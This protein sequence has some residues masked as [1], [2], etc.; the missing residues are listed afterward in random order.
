MPQWIRRAL[1]LF[2]AVAMDLTLGEPPAWAHPVVW[3]GRVIAILERFAPV[4]DRAQLVY[5]VLAVGGTAGLVGWLAG[6]AERVARRRGAG[7]AIVT[8][9]LLKST[10]SVRGLARAARRVEDALVRN[11]LT[12][13]RCALRHLVSRDVTGLP[14]PLVAAAAIESVAE[15]AGDAILAPLLW[16]SA[17]GLP[18]ACMYRALNTFDSMWGYR[19]RYEYLGKSAARLDDLLN[20]LPARLTACL[21]VPAAPLAGGSAGGAWRTMWRD[22]ARTASPNAG[23]P[24]SAMAGALGIELEKVGH[25]RLGDGGPP[26]PASIGAAV[27]LLY[28]IALVPLGTAGMRM[29]RRD[30]GN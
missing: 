11:D 3:V 10:F 4:G 30:A 28:L 20:L 1:P 14:A 15:N 12:G 26:T 5:G 24:M 13:A 16:Y 19:G 22:H 23:W 8:A 25:Y 27:R 2:L 18:A 17:G 9:Y 7:G 29:V 6:A 21:I